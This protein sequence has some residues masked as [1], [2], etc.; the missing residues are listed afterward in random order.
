M[1]ELI[2][3]WPFKEHEALVIVKPTMKGRK[4]KKKHVFFLYAFDKSHILIESVTTHAFRMKGLPVGITKRGSMVVTYD[5]L[6]EKIGNWKID[7]AS[8]EEPDVIDWFWPEPEYL[9]AFK[10]P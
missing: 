2:K 3:D 1:S 6:K 5:K 7:S 4:V 8:I 10:E 9:Q